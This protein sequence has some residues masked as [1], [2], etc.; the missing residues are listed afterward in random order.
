MM[1]TYL[2]QSRLRMRL[3]PQCSLRTLA[4][5]MVIAASYLAYDV[6]R[7]QTATREYP[8]ALGMAWNYGK[9][10]AI[11]CR[12]FHSPLAWIMTGHSKCRIPYRAV[13]TDVTDASPE[14]RMLRQLTR[15]EQVSITSSDYRGITDDVLEHIVPLEYLTEV[16]LRDTSVSD[17]G[18]RKLR[19]IL[20]GCD[21]RR[22]AVDGLRQSWARIPRYPKSVELTVAWSSP[23][24]S[25]GEYTIIKTPLGTRICDISTSRESAELGGQVTTAHR[26]ITIA[27]GIRKDFQTTRDPRGNVLRRQQ[28]QNK[29]A[30]DALPLFRDSPHPWIT[31]RFGPLASIRDCEEVTSI[32]GHKC[33]LFD[34]GYGLIWCDPERD[35]VICKFEDSRSSRFSIWTDYAAHETL[36]WIPTS[37][38]VVRLPPLNQ[39]N[40]R[41]FHTIRT[42]YELIRIRCD[43]QYAPHQLEVAISDPPLELE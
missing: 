22:G 14:L 27:D 32:R 29:D 31:G 13:L 1:T 6:P 15:L 21:V 30:T 12:V 38:T 11:D 19:R 10:I 8:I 7:I 26:W 17:S 2:N 33:R 36:G 40:N 5:L 23:P 4:V 24:S 16:A 25:F 39:P 34:A 43:S 41:G 28:P 37:W 3:R 18:I 9:T 42:D 20:P 35:H